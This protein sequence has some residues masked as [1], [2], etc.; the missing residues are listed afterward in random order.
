[1][2]GEGRVGGVGGGERGRHLV[3]TQGLGPRERYRSEGL[4]HLVEIDLS[5][6]EVS[7]LEGVLGGRDGALQ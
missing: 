1:V 2:R 3:S 4:V 7:P 6:R 5:D